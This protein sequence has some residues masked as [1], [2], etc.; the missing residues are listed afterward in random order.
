MAEK[1]GDWNDYMTPQNLA[2]GAATLG[3]AYYLLSG[4]E[5]KRNM[6]KQ[7]PQHYS[8][9][10]AQTGP[11]WVTTRDAEMPIKLSA[12]GSAA[13][14]PV[15]IIELVKQAVERHGDNIC[16]KYE[17]CKDGEYSAW[18]SCTWREHADNL[19]MMAKALISVGLNQHDSVSIMGFNSPEWM[20]ANL[21]CVLAGGIA[22]GIYTTCNAGQ[23]QYIAGHCEA[24]VIFVENVKHG[25]KVLE[26]E[27][28][29]PN[30][31]HL[32]IWDTSDPHWDTLTNSFKRIKALSYGDFIQLGSGVSD[33]DLAD[34]QA[35]VRPGHCAELIYT[36]G[37]TGNPKAV[38]MSHDNITWTTASLFD[39][40]GFP[41]VPLRTASYLPFS[42]VAA[43][44]VDIYGPLLYASKSENGAQVWF[45]R[46]TALK[47]SLK[48]TLQDCKPTMFFGVPRVWEK[49]KEAI[50][51]AKRKNPTGGAMGAV[52][53]W[54]KDKCKRRNDSL[55]EDQGGRVSPMGYGVAKKL[56][57]KVKA[58][59][60]L[61]KCEMFVTGA[62]PIS[63]DTLEYF[64]NLDIFIDEVY[65]MSE[66]AG[67]A[68]CG[69]LYHRVMGTTGPAMDGCEIKIDHV[70][71]RDKPN[72]GEICFRGRNIM[73]GYLGMEKKTRE[74]ID[75]EGFMHSGDV[76]RFDEW[77]C[78]SITGR[79]KE[80][81]ITEG[82]ENIAPVPVEKYLKSKCE[83]LSNVIMVGD[84]KKYC[85][86]L[87]SLKT[88]TDV[89]TE[90][91]L[92]NLSGA[93][94]DVSSAS[95]TVQEA[96][97][98]PKWKEYIEAGITAYNN[99]K[100]ACA[101]RAATI[102]YFRILPEDLSRP[103]GTLGPT[104]KVKRPVVQK[105]Y[106][107]LIDSMYQR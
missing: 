87:V 30:C 99:D 89:E 106:Q 22:A 93:A 96:M 105:L 5:T 47:G 77:G 21:G 90:L 80:L 82:G 33:Q 36:S 4:S 38:M 26:V 34:R 28:E 16:Y 12:R 88:T 86:A 29:L 10:A 100:K 19:N 74:S 72:E 17:P 37:T 41:D 70:E 64:K 58:K 24:K 65:G 67:P 69:R 107:E 57:G 46:P 63:R 71:G 78:V 43:Q 13:A 92:P 84:R 18:E 98:D 91:P 94:L 103:Q 39:S 51:E 20:T 2:M 53:D 97:E 7:G 35:K 23:V 15:T 50:L 73:M 61:E 81:L 40:I 85:V 3:V 1:N 104:M 11:H 54:A 66:S 44:L 42:H 56:M 55:S 60:G 8:D 27:N 79:I 102:K 6:E 48:N 62:A 101:S 68:S 95:K 75:D 45:A 59:L 32:V 76:G 31:S 83:A 14:K 49:F 25:K 52:V 9:Y